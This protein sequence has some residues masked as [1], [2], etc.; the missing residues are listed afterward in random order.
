MTSVAVLQAGG[1]SRHRQLGSR[2]GE[3]ASPA[4]RRRTSSALKSLARL[5]SAE[6]HTWP[7]PDALRLPHEG[8]RREPHHLSLV[9]GTGGDIVNKRP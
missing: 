2:T 8:L 1:R 4:V 6:R 5:L 9:P 7:A 3:T